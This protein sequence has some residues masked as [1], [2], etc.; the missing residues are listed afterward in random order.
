[1]EKNINKRTYKKCPQCDNFIINTDPAMYCGSCGLLLI[2]ECKKC[3]SKID[4]PHA[5][6]CK[7]CG[8]EYG[9]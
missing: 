6:Y 4:D 8:T 3:K 2:N 7:Y 5:K 9:E 1:M